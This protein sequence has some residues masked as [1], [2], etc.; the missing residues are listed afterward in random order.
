MASRY[1]TQTEYAL[2]RELLLKS[3]PD[4]SA[5]VIT[6]YGLRY[7]SQGIFYPFRQNS[8]VLYLSGLEEPDCALVL[9]I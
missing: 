2:R 7:L 5:A 6:G 9:G 8:N 4:H 3:L 1:L